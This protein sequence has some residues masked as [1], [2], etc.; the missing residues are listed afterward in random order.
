MLPP[1]S[2]NPEEYR[3]VQELASHVP[4]LHYLRGIGIKGLRLHQ[5][6]SIPSRIA[7]LGA[8]V[9]DGTIRDRSLLIIPFRSGLA[10]GVNSWW[11]RRQLLR[12]TAGSPDRWTLWTRFPSPELVDAL[13]SL[14]FGRLV[15][16]PIDWY[17]AAEDLSLADRQRLVQA[18]A[19]LAKRAMVIT[20]GLAL[21]ERFRSSPGGSHWLPFGHDLNRE[22][23]GEGICP[24]VSRPRLCVVAELDWR[25]DDVLLCALAKKHP[26]WQLVMAGPRR[27][28]WGDQL[29][30]FGNVRWLGRIPA[31][32]VRPV[33]ADSDVTLIPYRLTDW[34]SACLPVKVFEYLAEA[35][36]VVA[37]PL[38]ELTLLKDV[39]T[40]VPP[41]RFEAAIV[42][43]LST[44]VPG[45][46]ERR[47]Q[48]VTR[49]TLQD[50]ARRAAGLLQDELTLAPTA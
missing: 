13:E 36:P 48:A 24:S 7:G 25:L 1:D 22:S 28:P 34:T 29:A 50:R 26:D 40:L 45:T 39:V 16:E 10:T 43:A 11:I 38:P 3:F 17:A 20:G 9:T 14:A 47:L 31:A 23:G 46:K 27:R 15:Y 6:L 35:K 21:A 33:I 41:H 44:T 5:V 30:R 49:F 42:E 18:E 19:R 8:P 32:R 37:T 2:H 4:C 12:L